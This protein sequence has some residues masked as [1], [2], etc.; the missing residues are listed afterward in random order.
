[1]YNTIGEFIKEWNYEMNSTQKV[2][3]ALT[4]KSLEVEISPDGRTLGRVAWH[5][6][7]NI[8][9]YLSKFGFIIETVKDPATIPSSAKEIAERFREVSAA[10][11]ETVN[12]QWTNESLEKIQDAFGRDL[13]NAEILTLLIKHIVHH[14]G[15]MTVL[16][17]KAELR[18]PG[19]YGPAREEWSQMGMEAP[20]L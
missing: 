12:K 13:S 5:I 19:V 9:Q 11:V 15:Q 18:V 3:D 6:V 14:R 2:F 17:R 7:T 8:P 16:M 10:A 20:A 1:M 4:D